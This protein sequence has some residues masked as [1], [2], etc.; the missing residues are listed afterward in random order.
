MLC[1]GRV[2]ASILPR[3]DGSLFTLLLEESGHWCIVRSFLNILLRLTC[4][5][6]ITEAHRSPDVVVARMLK[7]PASHA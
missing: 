4:W 2:F 5:F 7:T 3:Q 6:A 1:T